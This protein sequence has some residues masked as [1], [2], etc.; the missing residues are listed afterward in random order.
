MGDGKQSIY[1]WRAGER[2]QFLH[3]P[4]I[5]K[6][7]QLPLISEWESKIDANLQEHQLR[8]NFRSRKNI[9]Y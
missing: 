6:G 5:Y 2:E 9:I 4:V 8:N 7:D 1:R 3:L